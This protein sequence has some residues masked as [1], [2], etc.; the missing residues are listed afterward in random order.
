MAWLL[1]RG[2]RD[3]GDEVHLATASPEPAAVTTT[4][5]ITI[6]SIRAQIP[7]RW[8][9]YLGLYNPPA[10]R[11]LRTILGR[12]RPDVVSAHNLHGDLSYACLSTADRFGIP[13]VFTA[14]DVMAIAYGKLQHNV[15]A[16][17]CPP[18]SGEIYR[19]PLLHNLRQARLR[20]NPLRNV[21]IRHVLRHHVR[22]RVAVSESLR[23]ALE[24]NGLPGFRVVHNGIAGDEWRVPDAE[25]AELRD[26]L[27]LRGRRV[28]LLAGR[29]SRAKGSLQALAALQAVVPRVPEATLLVLSDRPFARG[30]YAGLG[31]EH[32][33]VGGWMSGRE[34]AAAYGLASVII[35]PSICLDAF[36]SAALEGMAAGRPV[37]ATCH[38]GPPEIVVEGVTGFIVNPFDTAQFAR[39]LVEVL[40]DDALQARL[41]SAGNDRFLGNFMLEHYAEAMS[42]VLEE[43]I[44]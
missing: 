32:V 22:A 39:R 44:A 15:D 41:G 11:A 5:G 6:H 40:T 3:R 25:V 31:A 34:L 12:V 21:V 8:R 1:A 35:V 30:S 26:R 23:R 18:P 7:E 27:G 19:L 24:A 14:H 28:I 10:V 20:Y 37:I 13:V 42:A 4:D 43:V 29:I 17:G 33:R 38:G 16:S 9:A 2:L 36:P